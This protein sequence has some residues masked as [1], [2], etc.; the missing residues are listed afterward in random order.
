MPM[1]PSPK[2]LYLA[3][4]A[5]VT[6]GLGNPAVFAADEAYLRWPDLHDDVLVFACE[7]DLWR[8]SPDGGAAIRLTTHPEEESSPILSPD[9]S[10]LTFDAS[11]DG[12]REVYVMPLAGGLP[13]QV[14]FEGGSASVR[15]WTADGHVVF[16]STYVPGPSW[17][18]LRSVD[19]ESLEVTTLPLMNAT[20]STMSTDGETLYFT[21]F[22]LR[23]TGDNT[24]LYR[25]GS[26]AQLWRFRPNADDEAVRLSPDFEAPIRH[27][28]LWNGRVWFLS[29]ASGF[30]NV[31]SSDENGGDSTQHTDFSGFEPRTPRLHDGVLVYQRGA[32]LFRYDL[33]AG[34]ESKLAIDVTSDQDDRR[35]RWLDSPLDWLES[36]RMG[37]SGKSVALTARGRVAVA[38]PGARRRVE[39]EIPNSARA[40]EAVVGPEGESVFLILDRDRFGEIW[41]Y[42]ANGIGEPEQVT[43]ESDAHIWSIYPSPAGK[44]I[45]YTDKRARLWVLDLETKIRG[46]LDQGE[47]NDDS[48]FS[49]ISW[50]EKGRYVAYARSDGRGIRRLVVRDLEEGQRAVVT[51]GKYE[52]YAPAFSADGRWLYFVSDRNFVATPSSPWG[53]RNLGPQFDRRGKLYALALDPEAHFPFAPPTELATARADAQSN[54]TEPDKTQSNK[55]A[56]DKSKKSA[57][58]T[59]S[60]DKDKDSKSAVD[61]S[62]VFEGL[63]QR[64]WEVPAPAGNYGGLAAGTKHLYVVDRGEDGA[65]LKSLAIDDRKPKVEVF[66]KGASSFELSADRK[67]IFFQSGRGK[68]ATLAIVPAAAQA[69]KDLAPHRLRVGDWKLGIVP[70]E[71]WRQM[72]LDAWRMHREFAYDPDLRGVDWDTVLDKYMPLAERLG[73]RSELNDLLGQMAAELGILHSQVRSGDL[74]RDDESGAAASLGAVFEQVDGGLEIVEIW[75]GERARPSTLGPLLRPGVDVRVGDVVTSIDGR[76][77]RDAAGLDSALRNRAGQQV[78]LGLSRSGTERTAIVEPISAGAAS[79]LPYFHWVQRNR[80]KVAEASKGNVGYLHLRAM[81]GGDIASFARDFYEHHDKDGLIIDVRGNRGGNIDSWILSVLLRRVW[82]FWETPLG[83][84][85]FTNMQQTFRGHLA[86]LIDE[87]TYSDGETF[88]AGIKALELGPLFGQ[89]TAGAG[90]WLT[91][92]NRLVDRGAARI[93]EFPQFGLDGRWLIEGRGVSPDVAVVN[94]PVATWRGAD[95][96]LKAAL[97]YLGQRIEENPL[98]ELRA[99]P[100]PELGGNGMDVRRDSK[101]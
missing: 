90:I 78:R 83:G 69:P 20:D 56:A 86:V 36:S 35:L 6:L 31:W 41:R 10:W 81:G 11:Y 72:L 96:Q 23:K 84:P 9:G 95:A 57:D 63:A 65:V 76:S 77:V 22:G 8:T 99:R 87:G 19:P 48:P 80:E 26:M 5:A 40:R 82:A 71:E 42:P 39:L 92:R 34:V 70:F 38:F 88:S 54:E 55:N 46:I 75:D 51:D 53:D 7:G 68:S 61:A 93:A 44:K 79:R 2:P 30:T 17:S 97:E 67:K 28:M 45:L 47:G 27:P 74:P 62:V 12:A 21:R 3:V 85:P 59:E 29:D 91:S 15:G 49:D 32:D 101:E 100:L 24:R 58:A 13:R 14:T 64:L 98:P 94:P 66:A 37:A 4:L 18:V 33:E 1:I 43:E 73:H 52:A 89:T 60:D 25:G 50:S 16:R